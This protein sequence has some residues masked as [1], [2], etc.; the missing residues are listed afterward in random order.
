MTYFVKNEYPPDATVPTSKVYT[1]V[2]FIKRIGELQADSKKA[3]VIQDFQLDF[4]RRL[5]KITGY[6]AY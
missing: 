1:S 4:K 3:E 2:M 6:K 5:K